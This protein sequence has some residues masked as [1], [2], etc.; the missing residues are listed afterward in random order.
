MGNRTL[1]MCTSLDGFLPDL[2]KE[3]ILKELNIS[4]KRRKIK[5]QKL[6]DLEN[7]NITQS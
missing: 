3:M 6:E 1:V 7:T 5:I 2:K 4:K